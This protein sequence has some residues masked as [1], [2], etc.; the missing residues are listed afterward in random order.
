LDFEGLKTYPL[1]SKNSTFLGSWIMV[2]AVSRFDISFL[3]NVM[4]WDVAD[5]SFAVDTVTMLYKKVD[6]HALNFDVEIDMILLLLYNE[7]H[8][9]P[10]I[11]LKS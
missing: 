8:Q 7:K 6:F 4:E 2:Y 9:T 3:P 5:L 10:N 1:L 11:K